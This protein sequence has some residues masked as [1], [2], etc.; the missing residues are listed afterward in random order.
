MTVYKL[1]SIYYEE[2]ILFYSPSHCLLFSIIS[3]TTKI[4]KTVN[5]TKGNMYALF[6]PLK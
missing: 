5:M 4:I 2:Y 3:N 6:T 1:Y